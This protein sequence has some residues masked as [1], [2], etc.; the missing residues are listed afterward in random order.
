MQ[1]RLSRERQEA[2]RKLIEAQG[3]QEY[4]TRVNS[5]LT[6]Q[7]LQFKS[8]EAALD[9]SRSSNTKVIVLGG[10]GTGMPIILS[11]DGLTAP[12]SAAAAAAAAA[13]P[14]PPPA[15]AAIPPAPTP[16][17]NQPSAPPG[18]AQ[19]PRPR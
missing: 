15:P 12:P 8:I 4:Q 11:P 16:P 3:I 6:A 14:A 10:G 1:Y 19:V 17:P 7:L 5:T 2:D 18:A 9:L 13:A